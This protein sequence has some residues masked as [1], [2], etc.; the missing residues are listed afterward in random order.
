MPELK[1]RIGCVALA[2][3][4]SAVTYYFVE[5][6]LRWGKFGGY[7]AAGLL[8]IMVAI[9]ITGYSVM[10]HGGYM[11]RMTIH[12]A[13]R[14]IL[15]KVSQVRAQA[16]SNCKT[17]FQGW[18]GCLIEKPD[19]Q[20]TIALLGDS[21]A[22]AL[23]DGILAKECHDEGAV[24]FSASCALPLMGIQTGYGKDWRQKAERNR[25]NYK[26]IEKGFDCYCLQPI[27]ALTPHRRIF[28]SYLPLFS[29]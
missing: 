23:Y 5:P 27:L 6:R 10:K 7:K 1:V 17:I 8:S 13:D 9:G 24:L 4:M 2:V 3:V 22:G 11:T 21:H 16:S 14:E 18:D 25:F 15:H 20:N 19:G 26:F 28:Q 29:C 12:E